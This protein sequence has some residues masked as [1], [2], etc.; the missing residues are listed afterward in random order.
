VASVDGGRDNIL[1][2][3]E[4]GQSD[5]HM[6]ARRGVGNDIKGQIKEREAANSIIT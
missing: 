3:K 1:D 4:G 2:R 5:G 6:E